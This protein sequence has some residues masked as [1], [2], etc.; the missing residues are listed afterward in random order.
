MLF[1]LR[2][3][4]VEFPPRLRRRCRN[5]TILNECLNTS[6]SI[7]DNGCTTLTFWSVHCTRESTVAKDRTLMTN[8]KETAMGSIAKIA[9]K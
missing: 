4:T 5:K 7:A 2:A 9:T 6:M 3:I 1:T 8:S